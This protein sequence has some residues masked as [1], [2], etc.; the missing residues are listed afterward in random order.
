VLQ[1]VPAASSSAVHSRLPRTWHSTAAS[2]AVTYSPL[3]EPVTGA[4]K[5]LDLTVESQIES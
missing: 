4:L 1:H 3:K 5:P 2:S